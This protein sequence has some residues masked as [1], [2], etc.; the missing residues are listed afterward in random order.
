[1]E[2]GFYAYFAFFFVVCRFWGKPI[3]A[4]SYQLIPKA[5]EISWG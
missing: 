5:I 3:P 1:M 2:Y 4:G